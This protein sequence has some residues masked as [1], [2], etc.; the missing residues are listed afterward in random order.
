MYIGDDP[1]VC[2][3]PWFRTRPSWHGPTR[4]TVVVSAEAPPGPRTRDVRDRCA[5]RSPVV[6]PTPGGW[7]RYGFQ[8]SCPTSVGETVL[9][10]SPTAV[11]VSLP[12]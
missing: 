2:V 6:P 12:C 4:Y 10:R 8:E 9:H 11:Y 7:D 1:E 5:T 3:R